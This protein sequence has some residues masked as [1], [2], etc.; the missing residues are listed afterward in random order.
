MIEVK[1]FDYI[2]EINS[3][4]DERQDPVC[5]FMERRKLIQLETDLFH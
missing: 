5:K 1:D 2:D 3:S 4:L